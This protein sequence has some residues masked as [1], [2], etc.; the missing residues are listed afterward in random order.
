M[1]DN[2]ENGNDVDDDRP[3]VHIRATSKHGE[4]DVSVVGASGETTADIKD[5]AK[6]RFDH[7]VD[8]QADLADDE[9]D[10]KGV[11]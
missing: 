4:V 9:P 1:S 5:V 7:A 3:S 8:R 11:E 2:D 6:N 10:G